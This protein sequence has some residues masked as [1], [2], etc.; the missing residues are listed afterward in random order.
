MKKFTALLLALAMVVVLAACGDSESEDTSTD[1]ATEATEASAEATA[2]AE[3]DSEEEEGSDTVEAK[4]TV[5]VGHLLDITGTEAATGAQAQAAFEYAMTA[6]EAETGYTIEVVEGDCQSD[7]SKAAQAATSMVE[8]GCIAIF[9]PTQIG[10]KS[11]VAGALEDSGVPL[12]LYNGTPTGM[13]ASSS[14]AVA[15]GGGTA[16]FPTVM[17]DYAYNVLGYRTIYTIAQD[18]TGGHN[19]VDPFITCFEAL[20][21]EVVGS[22][23]VAQG[24]SD[25]SSYLINIINSGCDA[26]AG[27]TS[28]SDAI[29][30]WKEWY[31]SG[32]YESIPVVATM[33]GGF[34]DYYIMSALESA[35]S[36]ITDAILETGLYAPINYSYSIDSEEN[37][38]FVEG[39][40]E[41]HDGSVPGGNNLPGSVYQALLLLTNALDEVGIDAD[42]ETLYNAMLDCDFYGPEGHTV[43]TDSAVA[44][45][46]V[47]V[48]KVVVL[49]DGSY[50]YDVVE[51][52]EQVGPTGYNYDG[53]N[54]IG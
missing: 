13:I 22:D 28:S 7:S 51:T 12:V 50:N 20:G 53:E 29:A 5:K 3:D 39:W 6:I 2:E 41:A 30:F 11:A 31:A 42:S 4:G 46:D 49:D 8:E 27:W 34:S 16:G 21:G 43:F 52:Y 10:H 1:A 40:Q 44:T 18:T 26:I 54:Y 47:Y 37:N 25:W 15:L 48:V 45:K 36:A 33:H 23:Y 38:E 32:A 19:Y 24:T 9:G 14:W 17:A 35:N